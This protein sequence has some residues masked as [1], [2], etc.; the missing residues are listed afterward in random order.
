MSAITKDLLHTG[1]NLFYLP[2]TDAGI[3]LVKGSPN[4]SLP[5]N[6]LA[7]SDNPERGHRLRILCRS[8]SMSANVGQF[9]GPN[10]TNVTSN[11]YFSISHRQPGEIRLENTVGSQNSLTA[12][13]QGVYTCRIPLQ[14]GDTRDINVGIYPSG[15]NSELIA[16]IQSG[17]Y[18]GCICARPTVVTETFQL[19]KWSLYCIYRHLLSVSILNIH[20]NGYDHC[21]SYT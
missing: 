15:F 8:D 10:G 16:W 20:Y 13:Q 21:M 3:Q 4:G 11:G 12:S 14:N 2:F 5:N 6:A 17:R 1:C 9:I 7:I 19:D 18:I